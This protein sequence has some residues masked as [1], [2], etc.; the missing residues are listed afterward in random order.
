MATTKVPSGAKLAQGLVAASQET[1]SPVKT[2][3][4][5]MGG[6]A[7]GGNEERISQ[8]HLL[9]KLL[10]NKLTPILSV[11]SGQVVNG[12]EMYIRAE[13]ITFLLTLARLS[14]I[15]PVLSRKAKQ[16]LFE[17]VLPK[18]GEPDQVHGV[19]ITLAHF[20]KD[21]QYAVLMFLAEFSRYDLLRDQE[22]RAVRKFLIGLLADEN[23]ARQAGAGKSTRVVLQVD[24]ALI[25][26]VLVQALPIADDEI[27]QEI[28]DQEIIAVVPFLIPLLFAEDH[29]TQRILLR[30]RQTEFPDAVPVP[31][32][33]LRSPGTMP[34]PER[35]YLHLFIALWP[36]WVTTI[37]EGHDP[38]NVYQRIRIPL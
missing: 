33:S 23:F 9:G 3:A 11:T 31:T 27:I 4:K 38:T 15:D 24:R 32:I 10:S 7:Q 26:K 12:G 5:I 6:I 30:S 22:V 2:I 28:V 34:V 36:I 8:L 37:P 21:L 29:T 17:M 25:A 1:A 35:C 13:A 14:E 16:V 20:P 18:L 19:S